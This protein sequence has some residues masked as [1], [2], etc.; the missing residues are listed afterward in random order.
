[1]TKGCQQEEGMPKTQD[2]SKLRL[3][4]GE[5][6]QVQKYDHQGGVPYLPVDRST[7]LPTL[8][9]HNPHTYILYVFIPD[10]YMYFKHS[11]EHYVQIF[12]NVDEWVL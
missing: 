2:E 7:T 6:F 10:T 9:I 5:L 3:A 8:F 12:L 1:M 11:L 4:R